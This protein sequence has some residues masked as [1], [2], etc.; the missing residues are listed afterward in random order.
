MIEI[1]NTVSIIIKAKTKT[2]IFD[3]KKSKIYFINWKPRFSGNPDLRDKGMPT[4]VSRKSG[5][6]CNLS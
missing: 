6:D 2:S 1:S 3:Q 5:F 4:N